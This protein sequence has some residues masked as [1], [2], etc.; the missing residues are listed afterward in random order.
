MRSKLIL[1]VVIFGLVAALVAQADEPIFVRWLVADDPGDETIRMFWERSEREEL[2]AP[3]LVDL[4]TMLF[5]RG[6]PKDA[7]RMYHKALDLDPE[8][9]EAWF[10]IGLVEH[11]RGELHEARKAYK[12]CLKL[13][14][15][16]GWCNFYLGL[17]EEQ[18]GHSSAALDYFRRAFKFAPDLA[19][20]EVNPEMLTSDLALA[21][22]LREF[23][24]TNF[25]KSLPLSYLEPAEVDSVRAM[26]KP[27]PGSEAEEGDGQGV[28]D[29]PAPEPTAIRQPTPKAQP[30]PTAQR[31]VIP[32]PR[33][34]P[35]PMRRAPN[36]TP[37]PGAM[38]YGGAGGAGTSSGSQNETPFG[39]PPVHNV[40]PE[41]RFESD[42]PVLRELVSVFV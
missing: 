41:A 14:T 26:F 33:A 36:R 18:T 32:T 6:Y 22:R 15:G 28:V 10:R 1:A 11:S 16:H 3:G 30:T 9:Y 42:W 19:D 31:T 34:R 24:R 39:M 17:L 29:S 23:G 20:P 25:K 27:P 4:G 38:G 5:Y 2:E 37:K 40:S 12:R 35:A 13:L 7:L 21:A 8:L